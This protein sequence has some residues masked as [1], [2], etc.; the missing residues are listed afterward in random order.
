MTF[1]FG[2]PGLPFSSCATGQQLDTPGKRCLEGRFQGGDQGPNTAAPATWL[3]HRRSN[4]AIA[5]KQHFRKRLIV[6]SHEEL[7]RRAVG[8]P[9]LR[10]AHQDESVRG[11][12]GLR[13]I[14]RVGVDELVPRLRIVLAKVDEPD[15]TKLC[16]PPVRDL[17]SR[18]VVPGPGKLRLSAVAVGVA[19]PQIQY[20]FYGK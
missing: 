13:A 19:Q 2:Q 16:K 14:V 9:V 7:P 5:R 4:D 20:A 18:A 15:Q 12:I 17:P 1:F 6:P 11:T 3:R 10:Y 8:N